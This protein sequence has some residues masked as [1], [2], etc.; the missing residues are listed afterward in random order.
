MRG[1][2]HFVY[3]LMTCRQQA[4]LSD[5]LNRAVALGNGLLP[6]PK[7]ERSQLVSRRLHFG[8]YLSGR[9]IQRLDQP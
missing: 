1:D 4:R 9:L 7:N 6:K 5:Q 3:S 8:M 2:Q